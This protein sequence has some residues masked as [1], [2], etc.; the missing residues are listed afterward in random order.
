MVALWEQCPALEQRDDY[1]IPSKKY[2]IPILTV[3]C[4]IL[5]HL[6][7]NE[8]APHPHVE[9]CLQSRKAFV[10]TPW[11]ATNKRG[12]EHQQCNATYTQEQSLGEGAGGQ[13]RY[14]LA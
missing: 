6:Q 4:T 10:S 7:P 2:F 13:P 3:L 9:D 12:H 14:T 8:P 11:G 5:C 1:P